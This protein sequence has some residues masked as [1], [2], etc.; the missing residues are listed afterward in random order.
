MLINIFSECMIMSRNKAYLD[1]Q[2]N[3]KSN[4][5]NSAFNWLIEF[6][7]L[8]KSLNSKQALPSNVIIYK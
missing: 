5:I 1:L 8:I 3:N 2:K 6:I 4:L 7:E